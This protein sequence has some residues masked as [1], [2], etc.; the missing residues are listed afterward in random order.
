MHNLTCCS[1]DDRVEMRLCTGVDK[2]RKYR[3][4]I[5]DGIMRCNGFSLSLSP[6]FYVAFHYEAALCTALRSSVCSSV[7]F[8]LTTHCIAVPKADTATCKLPFH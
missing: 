6:N 3:D 7:P 5:I 4:I 2:R 1:A 8:R